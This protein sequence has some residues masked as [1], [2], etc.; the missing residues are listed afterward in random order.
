MRRFSE[1]VKTPNMSENSG[2]M[3]TLNTQTRRQQMFNRGL[4]ACTGGLDILNIYIMFV[5][6]G[7]VFWS[8][9]QGDWHSENLHLISCCM[10]HI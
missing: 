6:E 9:M 10:A 7:L 4:Y 3:A 5:K 2:R 8:F 1:T